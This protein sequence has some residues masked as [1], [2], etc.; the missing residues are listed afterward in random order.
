M[1]KTFK[2]T[3]RKSAIVIMTTNYFH[4]VYRG[5]ELNQGQQKEVKNYIFE[6]FEAAGL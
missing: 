6:Q 4:P 5:E 3:S 1:D 2:R